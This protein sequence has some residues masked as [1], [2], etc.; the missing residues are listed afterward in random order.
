MEMSDNWHFTTSPS[1]GWLMWT[2]EMENG[3]RW[4]LKRYSFMSFYPKCHQVVWIISEWD[5]VIKKLFLSVCVWTFI[6]KVRGEETTKL[7]REIL[8]DIAGKTNQLGLRLSL[9]PFQRSY[10][11]LIHFKDSFIWLNSEQTKDIGFNQLFENPIIFDIEYIIYVDHDRDY[12]EKHGHPEEL[13]QWH[14]KFL[15]FQFFRDLVSKLAQPSRAYWE[16]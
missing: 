2:S 10:L 1:G 15:L 11:I 7:D 5:S 9:H 8:A 6:C 13:R 4:H 14:I 16:I 3:A 12:Q